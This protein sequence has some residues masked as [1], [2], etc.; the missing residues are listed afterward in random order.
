[1]TQQSAIK[2]AYDILYERIQPIVAIESSSG[3]EVDVLGSCEFCLRN[4]EDFNG[5][6]VFQIDSY[7]SDNYV[8]KTCNLFMEQLPTTLGIE[9]GSIGYKLS[10]FKG[11]YLAVPFNENDPV[12]L[13]T[14]GG[15]LKRINFDGGFKIIDCTGN[16]AKFQLCESIGKYSVVIDLSLRREMYLRHV[17]KSEANTTYIVTDTGVIAINTEQFKALKDAFIAEQMEDKELISTIVTLNGLKT[18]RLDILHKDVQA[19]LG[20][21]SPATRQAIADVVDPSSILFMLAALR[22][23]LTQKQGESH[24]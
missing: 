15:Y 2:N 10:S 21:L 3:K 13:W 5:K 14:G 17:K 19:A 1:M 20:S 6:G 9:R 22:A 24:E 18:N 11:A 12:E 4:P 16:L 7:K 8:C 23:G